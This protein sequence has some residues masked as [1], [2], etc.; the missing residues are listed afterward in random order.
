MSS[1]WDDD[2]NDN[3]DDDD[4]DNDEDDD[5]NAAAAAAAADDDDAAAADDDDADVDD[6]FEMKNVPQKW[7]QFS[8]WLQTIVLS[9]CRL[10]ISVTPSRFTGDS[11]V[12]PTVHAGQQQLNRRCSALLG[13]NLGIPRLPVDFQKRGNTQ[14]ASG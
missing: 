7:R 8:A 5:D 2:D 9:L 4:D 10:H 1:F 11:T 3:D 6:D 14:E 13:F 12:F